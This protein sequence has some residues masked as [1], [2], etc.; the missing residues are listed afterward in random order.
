MRKKTI[1][2]TLCFLASFLLLMP[3]GAKKEEII[4]NVY[5]VPAADFI[6]YWDNYLLPNGNQKWDAGLK[7]DLYN[8]DGSYFGWG[9]Q[10]VKGIE[11]YEKGKYLVTLG[12]WGILHGADGDIYYRAHNNYYSDAEPGTR[13]AFFADHLSIWKGTGIYKGIHGYGILHPP[14][15]FEIHYH[16]A[17]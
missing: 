1:L 7:F 9:E 15:H 13:E 16:I 14:T 3:V 6:I 10:Y 2:L 5:T 17:P 4:W 11:R 8:E 12:G